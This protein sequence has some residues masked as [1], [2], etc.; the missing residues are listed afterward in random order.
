M[1]TLRKQNV[2]IPAIARELGLKHP[3]RLAS[4]LHSFR[5]RTGPS[6]R[7][8]DPIG[9]W[10]W[11]AYGPPSLETVNQ[12]MVAIEGSEDS[13]FFQK[14][15]GLWPSRTKDPQFL[16]EWC[17]IKQ[18]KVLRNAIDVDAPIFANE[19]NTLRRIKHHRRSPTSLGSLCRSR[20]SWQRPQCG[21]TSR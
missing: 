14:A 2:S 10:D 11:G 18:L 15:S 20:R 6:E 19:A 8:S 21:C 7:G 13:Q 1:R 5:I 4:R 3:L 12:S 9:R 17:T 16:R